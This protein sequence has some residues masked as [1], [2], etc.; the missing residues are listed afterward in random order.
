MNFQKIQAKKKSQLAAEMLMDVIKKNKFKSG[1]KLP[2]ERIMASEM[3]MSR[4]TLREAIAALQILGIIE[5]RHSQGNFVVNLNE[6]ISLS[7]TLEAIFSSN[8]DPFLVIDARIAFEPGA[9]ALACQVA[10]D[11]DLEEIEL[12]MKQLINGI[13]E[14]NL[15]RYSQ[16]DHDFHMKIAICTDNPI[17]IQTMQHIIKVLK[18]PLWRSMKQSLAMRSEIRDARVEEHQAIY[19][20]LVDRDAS[21]VSN[22]L[23]THLKHSKKRL[24]LEIEH[25]ETAADSANGRNGS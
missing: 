14:N 9:A 20:G 23:L 8:D 25:A 10:T 2:P 21:R 19:R 17:I 15:V 4:N 22:S 6:T 13:E 7:S 18:Q 16:A 24:T 1:D 11:K 12:N 5:V 3:G